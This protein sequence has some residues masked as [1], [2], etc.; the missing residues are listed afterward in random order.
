MWYPG[1]A[2][3]QQPLSVS[4]WDISFAMGIVFLMKSNVFDAIFF[5]VCHLSATVRDVRG[6][7]SL[8]GSVFVKLCT[9]DT[10]RIFLNILEHNN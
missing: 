8:L 10:T 4:G 1:S 6:L 3:R 7:L 2:W 9:K 5:H